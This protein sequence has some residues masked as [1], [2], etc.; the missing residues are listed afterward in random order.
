MSSFGQPSTDFN[1][2]LALVTA[3]SGTILC[4]LVRIFRSW[5]SFLLQKKIPNSNFDPQISLCET[6]SSLQSVI[7]Y[8]TRLILIRITLLVTFSFT[9]LKHRAN[10]FDEITCWEAT[11]GRELYKLGCPLRN[12]CP[13]R[14]SSKFQRTSY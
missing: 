11:L 12:I 6:N 5:V 8:T 4:R 10:V 9:V 13:S 7:V 3:I 1:F 14:T 2:F